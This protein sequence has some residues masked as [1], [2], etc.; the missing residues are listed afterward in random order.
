VAEAPDDLYARVTA[1]AG[2]DGRLPVPEVAGWENFP[3]EADGLVVRRL[4]PPSLPEAPRQGEDP[5]D[6]HSCERRDEGIW[7]N[8]RWRV[9]APAAP[10]GAPLVL[11][12]LPLEHYDLGDLPDDLAA[13]LGVLTVRLERAMATVE[14]VA[15][16]H[17]SRWGDGGAHLHVWFL[18]R[19]AGFAQFRGT[20]FALWDD[21]L[22]PTPREQWLAD[23]ADVA[24]SLVASCGGTAQGLGV[25]GEGEPSGRRSAG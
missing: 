23:L 16:V 15:R 20:C 24:G 25:A 17:V 3:F 14:H 5:A 18:A 7:A 11:L 13:E 9:A 12:L 6:C 19:P 2:V 8:E 21:I 4:D 22:P 10:T 1:A